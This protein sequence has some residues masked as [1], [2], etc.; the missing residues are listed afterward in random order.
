[1]ASIPEFWEGGPHDPIDVEKTWR[2][3]VK[4]IGSQVVEDL[5]PEPRTFE[6]ADFLFPSASMVAELK[7]IE[8]EFDKNTAIREKFLALLERLLAEDPSWRPELLGGAGIYPDWFRGE[9]IRLFRPSLS[10]VL[11]K[12]NRQIKSTKEHF[13]ITDS[14]GMLI[15]V[16]DGF[17]GLEPHFVRMLVCD[18]LINSYSSIDCF[19]YITVNR[20]VE[21]QG[22][23]VPRL[24]W[25]PSYSDRAP[26][27]L[28]PF[29]DD[30]GRRWFDFLE[31]K[32]GKFS[33]SVE[34]I[35]KS[36]QGFRTIF[37]RA[38]VLPGEKS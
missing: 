27:S 37:S 30:L 16:N 34:E 15:F 19:L 29:V 24:L 36:N 20:Y 25:I 2:E 33:V 5:V 31:G 23:N 13:G 26:D 38:I 7:E 28:V 14:T 9:F 6:N 1:M 3:F 8:T 10:R 32:I 11:K 21:I 18:I 4:F 12:A 35:P 22:S 17:T